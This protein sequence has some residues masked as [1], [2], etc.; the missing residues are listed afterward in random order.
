MF[1]FALI[2]G[3]F[4]KHSSDYKRIRINVWHPSQN[5]KINWNFG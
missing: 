4:T 5:K 1:M 3:I 2:L